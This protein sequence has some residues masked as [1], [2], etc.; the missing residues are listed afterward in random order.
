MV[1]Q[2]F[3]SIVNKK[4]MVGIRCNNRSSLVGLYYQSPNASIKSN[5][6]LERKILR[7]YTKYYLKVS[8]ETTGQFWRENEPAINTTYANF[9]G[10]EVLNEN[11]NEKSE[12]R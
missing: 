9:Y 11:Q 2:L 7:I 6:W 10:G 12:K 1:K 5:A 8:L 3:H 4:G